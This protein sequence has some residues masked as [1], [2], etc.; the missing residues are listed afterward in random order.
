MPLN[1]NQPIILSLSSVY[2]TKPVNKPAVTLQFLNTN[3]S[4]SLRPNTAVFAGFGRQLISAVECNISSC[5]ARKQPQTHHI[6]ADTARDIWWIG[7]LYY[8]RWIDCRW[9]CN[10]YHYA[11][12]F[13]LSVGRFRSKH[14]S[15]LIHWFQEQRPQ[16]VLSPRSPKR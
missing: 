3:S 14:V 13:P 1:P 2:S 9:L 5:V 12:S 7:V 6:M 15:L 10:D 8:I 11:S 16:N 4:L